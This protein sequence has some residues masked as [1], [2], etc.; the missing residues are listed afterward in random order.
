MVEFRAHVHPG[1][2]RR[3]RVPS[4][5]APGASEVRDAFEEGQELLDWLK[6]YQ[7]AGWPFGRDTEAFLLWVE[8]GME[9]TVN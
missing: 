6:A 9:T 5:H 7:A 4:Q 1:Y 8:F 3:L 2:G